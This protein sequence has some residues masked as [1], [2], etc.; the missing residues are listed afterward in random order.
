MQQV[1]PAGWRKCPEC[2][3]RFRLR[4]AYPYQKYCNTLC[5]NAY[6]R[7]HTLGQRKGRLDG[8][9][10]A[11][12]I[13]MFESGYWTYDELAG[14]FRCSKMWVWRIINEMSGQYHGPEYKRKCE[15]CGADFIGHTSVARYCATHASVAASQ[16]TRLA[17]QQSRAG[18]LTEEYGYVPGANLVVALRYARWRRE[19][20]H[21]FGVWTDY[22]FVGVA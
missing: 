16:R 2:H 5:R 21:A 9:D 12:I 4:S 3:S 1:I 20:Y 18:R 15:Y 17:G 11:L 10:Y 13:A 19:D 22:G 6:R 8:T 14:R 7:H